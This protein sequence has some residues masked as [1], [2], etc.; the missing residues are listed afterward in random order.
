MKPSEIQIGKTYVNRGAGRTKRT[1]LGIGMEHR[2]ARWL[3]DPEREPVEPGVWFAQTGGSLHG[4]QDQLYLSSFAQW[5]KAEVDEPSD[6]PRGGG[7]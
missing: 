7:T 5:A 2:P 3:G 1:V 4:L 6:A